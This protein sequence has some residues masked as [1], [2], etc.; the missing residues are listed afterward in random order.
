V[1]G[2]CKTSFDSEQK[3]TDHF[4]NRLCPGA[5]A[6]ESLELVR[7][8]YAGMKR[9]VDTMLIKSHASTVCSFMSCVVVVVCLLTSIV[10]RAGAG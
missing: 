2:Q 3:R 5:P 9:M 6:A 1:C 8:L 10:T 7:E 4:K